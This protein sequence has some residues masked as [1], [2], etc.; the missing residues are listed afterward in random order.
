MRDSAALR[1]IFRTTCLVA[2]GVIASCG[3]RTENENGVANS[4]EPVT[5]NLSSLVPV[6]EPALDRS[7]LLAAVAQAASAKAAGTNDAQ[8][9]RALDGRQFEVRIRFGCKGPS[10]TL[11]EDWLGWSFG[12]EG[13]TLRVRAAPTVAA[14]DP[15]VRKIVGNAEFEAIEGFW[16]PRPWLLQAVCPADQILVP[17][18]RPAADSAPKEEPQEEVPSAEPAPSEPVPKWPRIGLAEF[19]LQSDSR[20]GRRDN[21]AYQAVKTLVEQARVGATGF[22]LVLSGRL[23]ALPGRKVIQCVAANPESPPECLVSGDF[24]Q[25]WIENP[26][27]KE[28]IAQWSHG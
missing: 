22:N 16:I 3:P 17:A 2:V 11:A 23:Q 9:Q 1:L 13:K 21:R 12:N 26:E 25:V 14:D 8:A 24:D 4:A 15:L 10:P 19:Y 27:T 20:T 5:E 28:I 7:G 18:D 6:P